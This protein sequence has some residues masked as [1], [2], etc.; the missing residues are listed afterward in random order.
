MDMNMEMEMEMELEMELDME[1]DMELEMEMKMEMEMEWKHDICRN[2][3]NINYCYL[4]LWFEDRCS[5]H[6]RNGQQWCHNI[7]VGNSKDNYYWEHIH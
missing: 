1:L 3:Y 2:K 5:L 7:H 6:I 4:E